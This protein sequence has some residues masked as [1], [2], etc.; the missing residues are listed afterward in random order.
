MFRL[1]GEDSAARRAMLA[2]RHR[3]RRPGWTAPP[4]AAGSGLA[5]PSKPSG[6]G[7]SRGF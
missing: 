7:R 4:W 6:G 3:S 5:T 2:Y 1:A